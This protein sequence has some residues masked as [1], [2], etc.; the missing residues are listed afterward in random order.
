MKGVDI[1]FK[2]ILSMVMA[3]VM[4]MCVGGCSKNM[5]QSSALTDEV[6]AQKVE[7][8]EMDEEFRTHS[9]D[10]AFEL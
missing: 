9:M 4:V 3:G 7:T 8:L 2:K 10:F 6:T 1:L 5:I